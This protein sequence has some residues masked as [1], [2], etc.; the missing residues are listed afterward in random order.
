MTS[1]L[2]KLV[3]NR[4]KTSCEKFQSFFYFSGS[5]TEPF[6]KNICLVLSRIF[7]QRSFQNCKRNLNLP[8]EETQKLQKTLKDDM[9]LGEIKIFVNNSEIYLDKKSV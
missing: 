6:P 5:T 7:I 2:A 1:K 8:A 3:K 4:E 9:G